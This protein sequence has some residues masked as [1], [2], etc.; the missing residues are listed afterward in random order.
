V[1]IS[2]RLLQLFRRSLFEVFKAMLKGVC[3]RFRSCFGKVH[4]RFLNLFRRVSF[5]VFEVISKES[6]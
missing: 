4:A 1:R 6:V 3:L 5:E 2:L